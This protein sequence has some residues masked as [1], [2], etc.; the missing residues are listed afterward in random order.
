MALALRFS[1]ALGVQALAV[2]AALAG[3]AVWTPLL[4]TSAESHTP[5][6]A[7]EVLAARSDNP[8]LQWFSTA[9]TAL[10]VKVSGVLAGAR[11]AVAI[12]SLNDGPPRSFLLGERLSPGVR[13]TAIAGDGVEIE[14]GGEKVRVQLDT[15]LQAPALPRLTRP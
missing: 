1:P 7:A 4:L 12:L 6:A 14:R 9:P 11:G 15:L 5:P 8:A 3:V 10:Q 2:V 13:L